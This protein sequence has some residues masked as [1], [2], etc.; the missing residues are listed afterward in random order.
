MTLNVTEI[1]R[2]IFG[3]FSSLNKNI[4]THIT[5]WLL[6]TYRRIG[7]GLDKGDTHNKGEQ[8]SDWEKRE[9]RFS[10]FLFTH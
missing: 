10:L 9:L 5:S 2:L 3:G 4:T 1:A 8:S 6:D 7:C